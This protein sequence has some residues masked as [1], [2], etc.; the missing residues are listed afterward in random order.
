MQAARSLPPKKKKN[1][2]VAASNLKYVVN[3]KTRHP[4]TVTQTITMRQNHKAIREKGAK[5]KFFLESAFDRN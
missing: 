5:G 4:F 2:W 3:I 1:V